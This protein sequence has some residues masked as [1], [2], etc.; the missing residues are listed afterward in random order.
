LF[1]FSHRGHGF[2][3]F[4]CFPLFFFLIV[5]PILSV[6]RPGGSLSLGHVSCH[7]SGCGSATGIFFSQFNPLFQGPIILFPKSSFENAVLLLGRAQCSS[8]SLC[9]PCLFSVDV[10]GG[11]YKAPQGY[12]FSPSPLPCLVPF[13][14]VFLRAPAFTWTHPSSPCCVFRDD[15][16]PSDPTVLTPF[17]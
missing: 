2:C 16:P 9:P 11:P 1:L 14:K 6:R 15:V 13:F 5:I 12:T 10:R 4:F 3:E 7:R 8:V 17:W